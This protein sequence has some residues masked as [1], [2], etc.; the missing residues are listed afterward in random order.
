MPEAHP[1][2]AGDCPGHEFR[3]GQ[4]PELAKSEILQAGPPGPAGPTPTALIPQ[5]D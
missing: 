2:D 3:R 4:P 5:Y 1:H